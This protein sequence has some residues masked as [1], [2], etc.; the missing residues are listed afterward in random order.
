MA[1]RWMGWQTIGFCEIDKFCQKVLQKHWPG[2][3]IYDDITKLNGTKFAGAVDIIS[4]GFPCQDISAANQNGLGLSG[5]RSRLWFEMLRIIDESQPE[6]V[7]GENVANYSR[8]ELDVIATGLAA[9]GYQLW[10]F[11]IPADSVGLPT[12]ERHI[13]LI[14]QAISKRCERSFEKKVSDVSVLSSEFSRSY[15]GEFSRWDLPASRVCGVGER[16]SRRVDRLRA[17]GNA[18]VPQVAFQIFQAI[19]AVQQE[20]A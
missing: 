7:I 13:W 4:G 9:I 1:A 8:L 15:P 10:P 19:E 17:L 3:V 5:P 14:A 12:V 2:V 6:Y 11:D 18:I 16:V 20:E